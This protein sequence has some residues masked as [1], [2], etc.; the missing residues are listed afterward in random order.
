MFEIIV[1]IEP[2][3]YNRYSVMD[4]EQMVIYATLNKALY[5]TLRVY[6]LFWYKLT[7]KLVERGLKINSDDWCI[8]NKIL[9]GFNIQYCVILMNSEYHTCKRRC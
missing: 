1:K 4:Q 9:Q 2:E 7:A 5:G 3:L 6:L 8:S